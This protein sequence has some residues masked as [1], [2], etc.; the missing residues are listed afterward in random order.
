MSH[1]AKNSRNQEHNVLRRGR[2]RGLITMTAIRNNSFNLG[3][4]RE[5]WCA[6]AQASASHFFFLIWRKGSY[7]SFECGRPSAIR[8]WYDTSLGCFAMLNAGIW[9]WGTAV[10]RSGQ[11][12]FSNISSLY[13]VHH[14]GRCLEYTEV[15]GPEASYEVNV[16]FRERK[17]TYDWRRPLHIH[18][19]LELM[20]TDATVRERNLEKYKL[21]QNIVQ[22]RQPRTSN[23]E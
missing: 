20:L 8:C 14:T 15:L 21:V 9:N 18:F 11:T 13:I 23:L 17:W 19:P 16:S 22:K 2:Y 7:I 6:F 5:T 10:L 1:S 12:T 4:L 3:R